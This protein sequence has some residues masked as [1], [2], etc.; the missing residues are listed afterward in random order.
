MKDFFK[1]IL[2]IL[3]GGGQANAK[4]QS[5]REVREPANTSPR[6]TLYT[7]GDETGRV[8]TERKQKPNDSVNAVYKRLMDLGYKPEA[9]AGIL[10]N[11]DVETGSSFAHDQK[12]HGGGNGYGLFQFDYMKP[13]Y[14][15]WLSA[16]N[17]K[18]SLDSQVDFMHDIVYGKNQKLIGTGNAKKLRNILQDG[19]VA[20]TAKGFME[21]FEKPGKPHVNRRLTSAK[22]F[23]DMYFNRL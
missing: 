4:T 16:E 20:S 22:N 9:I 3:A 17:K 10:G 14:H 11:I 13:H 21:I 5:T 23:Y 15:K 18:D 6:Y 1:M 7:G 19:D 12:Q 8:L 2:S